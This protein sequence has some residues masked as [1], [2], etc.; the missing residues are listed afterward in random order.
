MAGKPP[1]IKPVPAPAK[2]PDFSANEPH[3]PAYPSPAMPHLPLPPRPE[4][5]HPSYRPD[6]VAVTQASS[7]SVS[8]LSFAFDDFSKLAATPSL[9]D[10]WIHTDK[11]L[12]EPDAQGIR[13]F[14]QRQYVAV[15][16][17][18]F[19]QVVL[20]AESGLFRATLARE[21]NPSGPLLKPDSEGRFWVPL[22]SSDSRNHPARLN[23][24][25][26]RTAELFHRVGYSVDGFSEVT[27]T[28]ILAVSGMD[29]TLARDSPAYARSLVLLQDALRRLS[30]DQKIHTFITQMQHPDP[31]VRAQVDPQLQALL[32]LRE[33]EPGASIAQRD[34]AALFQNHERAFELDCDENTLQMRRIFPDLPKAAAEALW[35][36]ASAAERLHMHNQPGM[37]R[38]MAEEALLVLRDVRL[39]RAC[40]GIYLDSVSSPDSDRL[41]LHMIG[42]L[43]QWPRDVRIEI[44]QDVFD[45]KVLTAIGDV[46][47]S[48]HHVLVQQDAGYVISS[49]EGSSSKGMSDLYSAVWFLLLPVQR[50]AFGVAEGGG[51]TLQRLIRAQPLPSRQAV[52]ELLGLAPIPMTVDSATAQYR[53]AWKL[54]GGADNNPTSA[55]T[56]VD[57]VHDLYPQLSGEEVTTFINERLKSDLAGVMMR[58]EKEFATLCSELSIWSADKPSPHADSSGQGRAPTPAEQRQ[59]REQFSA[60]LQDIWRRKS[61]SRW[62]YGDYHFSSSVDF[63]GELP[64]LSARFEYV[65]ELILTAEKPGARI[66][67]FLDSFPN[68]KYLKV[69]GVEMQEFP[70]GIFQMRELL[71]LT[72]DSCSLRLSDMTAEGLAR[73][74]TLTLLNLARNPL[75]VAPP[76]GFM[77]DLT[78]LMLYDANLS[79]VPSGIDSLKELEVLAL[80]NNNISEVGDE[81]FDIPDTQNLFVGLVN[82]PLSDASRQRITEYL[83]NASMDRKIEIEMEEPLSDVESDSESSESGFSTGSESD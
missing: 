57:R 76:V 19:V 46:L 16:D 29:E 9:A 44:R 20:D 45:G 23:S 81:L 38:Q 49:P 69:T 39:A 2:T 60:K 30:L 6:L 42:R 64:R 77:P 66:G 22:Q 5:L 56:V 61:V 58:L 59:A 4:H 10:Y 17:N 53:Q 13:R 15:A 1:K 79:S 48:F 75:T 71:Q 74:E 37:P 51:Q 27:I 3:R 26:R 54:R 73:M 65:T 62:G 34:R 36:D 43:A 35:R 31:L 80:Q 52:S 25:R 55:K 7:L 67:A 78:E 50:Q 70:S 21:L 72:L 32:Q 8:P 11:S 41:A 68:V 47:T 24:L 82:N 40:E 28:R 83:E 14:R 12:G 63:S 18:H 33:G